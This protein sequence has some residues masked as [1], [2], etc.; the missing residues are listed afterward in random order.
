MRCKAVKSNGEPCG[1]YAQIGSDFCYMHDPTRKTASQ[2]S[3]ERSLDRLPEHVRTL[4][5]VLFVLD[6]ALRDA[7]MLENSVSRGQLLVS[8]ASEYARILEQYTAA[9]SEDA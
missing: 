1:S 7:L 5:D 8:L 4:D 3:T 9:A 6:R 2:A